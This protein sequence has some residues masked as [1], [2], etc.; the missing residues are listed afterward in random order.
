MKKILMITIIF[1]CVTVSA[2]S[3]TA[4]PDDITRPQ[5]GE[6]PRYP[7]DLIIG[8][9]GKGQASENAYAYAKSALNA[10]FKGADSFEGADADVW[11]RARTGIKTVNAQKFRLGGGREET[12]GS[13]SFIF[14]FIGREQWIVGELY[15]RFTAIEEKTSDE[16]G[17]DNTD[18]SGWKIDGLILDDPRTAG[19]NLES[20]QYDFSPYER[21]F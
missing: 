16:E 5:R 7:H 19:Q 21:F 11:E 2:T 12:D 18:K 15:I 20:Y 17:A 4:L 9:L 13:V 3:D 14:R 10:L 6:S 8:E 1:I